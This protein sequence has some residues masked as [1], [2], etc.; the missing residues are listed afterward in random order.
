MIKFGITTLLTL[1][2]ALI[3]HAIAPN[4]VEQELAELI[5]NHQEQHRSE[6]V[7]DPT[8]SF[9]ARQKAQHLASR[10]YFS[11]TTP[12]GYG[13]NRAVALAGYDL[14]AWWGD[15]IADNYIESL[16]GG[17]GSA[18]L[19]F[20]GWLD[21][22]GHGA[23]VL[24]EENEDGSNSFYVSQTRYGVGYFYDPDSTYK[25]Y[26]VFI[27]AP[28]EPGG[29]QSFEPYVEWLF[30]NFTLPEID[31]AG[32]YDFINAQGTLRVLEFLLNFDP[33]YPKKL[34]SP[35]CN[36]QTQRFE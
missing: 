31:A 3:A 16:S 8:L 26:Y 29:D 24:A 11:H 10:D 4:A 22:P 7:C 28:P 5:Q 17:Y 30:N 12:D 35:V 36:V 13:P 19:A 33:A 21:S 25:R 1:G 32:A 14:P 2:T 27:S 9:V 34:P 23:H 15:G 20:N 18:T 6:M